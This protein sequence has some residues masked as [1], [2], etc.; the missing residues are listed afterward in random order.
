MYLVVS[1][2]AISTVL[3]RLEE[4][5]QKPRYYISK[6]LV[7]VETK[8]IPLKKVALD[9][10]HATCRL[11]HYFQAHP[12]IVLTK[13]TLEALLRRANFTERI[14]KWGTTLGTYDIKYQPRTSVEGQVYC[15]DVALKT[16]GTTLGLIF[17]QAQDVPFREN[18][19]NYRSTYPRNQP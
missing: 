3:I 7:D 6:T 12:V 15:R 9:L 5:I 13:H 17:R 10:V 19:P 14:A 11:P 18:E 4:D 1:N 8:Y 16:Q 2:H